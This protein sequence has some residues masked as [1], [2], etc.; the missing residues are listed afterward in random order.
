MANIYDHLL[1][2][3]PTYFMDGNNSSPHFTEY[4]QSLKPQVRQLRRGYKTKNQVQVNYDCSR[5]Q[6]SYL[7]AYYPHYVEMAE[8]ILKQ[9]ANQGL[10]EQFHQNIEQELFKTSGE[11][12][13]SIFAAGAAPEAVAICQYISNNFSVETY[14]KIQGKLTIYT[15]DLEDYWTDSRF[16]TYHG[17]LPNYFPR[18]QLNLI[19]HTV[20]LL[21]EEALEEFEAE[22]RASHWL[23][24]QNCLNELAGK[25]EKHF[26]AN[27]N[28]LLKVMP[29]SSAVIVSDLGNYKSSKDLI[30]HLKIKAVDFPDMGVFTELNSQQYKTGLSLPSV[31]TDYLLTG[32]NDLIPRKNINYMFLFL[33]K[34]SQEVTDYITKGNTYVKLRRWH[35]AI[36][37][38]SK[39]LEIAPH[40]YLTYS[41]RASA[42]RKI[43]EYEK[44]IQDY[45][46]A[47]TLCQE[48]AEDYYHRS[49]AYRHLQDYDNAIADCKQALNLTPDLAAAY[50]HFGNLAFDLEE[51]ETALEK[52]QQALKYDPNLAMVHNNLGVTYSKL[53]QYHKAKVSYDMAVQLN[54]NYQKARQNLEK[55]PK[56]PFI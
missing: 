10:L 49:L 40:T 34:F 29:P 4:L 13:L 39:A 45:T 48:K 23:M 38:Y 15:F 31:I 42:Y 17:L 16:L 21:A 36:K 12:T 22:I 6:A 5:V 7:L 19:S 25:E 47:L 50:N 33:E 55:I 20:D 3:L 32:E 43:G 14:G 56:N 30:Q 35:R 28:Y 53:N 8:M 1:S 37:E 46:N 9:L 26:I 11:L 27:F 41:R 2:A 44:A 24:F 52:Y 18:K 51:Y 54:P